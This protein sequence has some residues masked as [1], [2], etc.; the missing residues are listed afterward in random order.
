MSNKKAFVNKP[1][2]N[3]EDDDFGAILNCAV[4]YSLGRQSYMPSLVIGYITPL[5]PF[6]NNRTLWCLKKDV[7]S[8]NSYGDEKIDKPAWMTF[9]Q[10]VCDEIKQREEKNKD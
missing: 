6:I 2:I 8:A 5:L 1:K 7:G 3:I 4:R 10:N 9:Y